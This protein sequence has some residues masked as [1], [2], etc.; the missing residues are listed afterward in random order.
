MKINSEDLWASIIG[1]VDSIID[2]ATSSGVTCQF[3]NYDAHANIETLPNANLIGPAEFSFEN[4]GQSVFNLTC[5]VGFSMVDD[6][7]QFNHRLVSGI[8][9]KKLEPET[10]I[11]ILKAS[12]G[13]AIGFLTLEAPT[14]LLPMFAPRLMHPTRMMWRRPMAFRIS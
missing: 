10:T 14:S 7:E 12:T 3:I 6:P 11:P 13:M 1:F 2:E 4:M 8:I 5:A 9:S